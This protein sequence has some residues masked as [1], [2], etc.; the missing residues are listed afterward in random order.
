MRAGLNL[1]LVCIGLPS[2]TSSS[3]LWT[4]GDSSCTAAS[5]ASEGY[6][7][8][9][10]TNPWHVLFHPDSVL[11]EYVIDYGH[12]PQGMSQADLLKRQAYEKALA[13]W[14][15]KETL[16]EAEVLKSYPY[17]CMVISISYLIPCIWRYVM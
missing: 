1:L 13:A 12:D 8:V 11:V 14:E 2:Q 3:H 16:R 10:T 9:T 15:L 5:L 7:S 17:D 6:D 4:G